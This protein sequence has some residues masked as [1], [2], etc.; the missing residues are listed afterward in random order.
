MSNTVQSYEAY[1]ATYNTLVAAEPTARHAGL[2]RRL[3]PAGATVLEIGSGPGRDADYLESLG[4]TVRR[5]DA[6]QA[7]LDIQAERGKHGELLDVIT[8]ELGGPYDAVLAECVLIHVGRA[9]ID[10]VLGKIAAA[11]RPGGRF[12]VS[13]REGEGEADGD[14]LM[15][16]WHR[17]DFA[18]QLTA[19]GFEIT[20]DDHHVD[21]DGDA[22]LTFLAQR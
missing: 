8:D 1:A 11:L 16:Y 20:W 4:V 15:A 21:C 14:Y 2:L 7:F 13:L 9:D 18:A 10:A 5:T 22:W 17:A 12:L 19:A 6:T 3:A